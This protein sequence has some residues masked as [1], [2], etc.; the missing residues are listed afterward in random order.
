MTPSRRCAFAVVRRVF[1]DGAYADRAFRAEADRSGLTGR[2]RAFAMRLAYGAVQRRRRSTGWSSGS[3]AAPP[4]GS[5]RPCWRPCGSAC[6][7]WPIWTASP[8]TRPWGRASSSPSGRGGA[9]FRLVN[10]VLR[11]ADTGGGRTG[12]VPGRRDAGRARRCAHSH[13]DWIAELWWE[14]LGAEDARALMARDNEP[15]ESAVR[16]EPLRTTTEEVAQALERERRAT[17]GDPLLPEALV[18]AIP[19]DLHGSELFERGLLMP[20]SRGSMLVARAVDPRPG[21]RVL[22]LCAAPGA[23]TTHLAA[24]MEDRRRGRRRRGRPAAC[25]GATARTAGASA[26]A[27]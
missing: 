19:Y 9:G 11:R 5:T 7:S 2:D 15:P 1:E 17:T 6:T 8:I 16:V 23:K 13:P 12:R 3:R 21:E 10:A 26:R 25:G 20:Q 14:A 27:A 22:D 4:S 18:L 24:L